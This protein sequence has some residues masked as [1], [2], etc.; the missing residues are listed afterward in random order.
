MNQSD[1][2][3][4]SL[5]LSSRNNELAKVEFLLKNGANVHANYDRAL[6]WASENGHLE[7]V[8]LLKKWSNL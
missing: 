6:L 4:R 8:E 3:D 5:T 7:V 1:F 2:L